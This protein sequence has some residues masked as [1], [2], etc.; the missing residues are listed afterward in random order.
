V[1]A[2]Q[3]AF[4]A[5][6][7]AMRIEGLGEKIARRL[8]HENLLKDIADIYTLREHDQ[9]L[10]A[11]EG[12][13]EISVQ[14]LFAEIEGSKRRPFARV[15]F[16]LGIP[17]V[18]AQTARLLTQHFK[19]IDEMIAAAPEQFTEIYGIGNVV[20]R[21]IHN[22][23]HDERNLSRI[24]RLRKAGLYFAAGAEAQTGG[25]LSGK[26]VCVTGRVE[27]FTR[28]EWKEIIEA[29]GGFFVSSVSKST[30]LLLAGD[31]A[32]S[33]LA[34][35]QKLGVETMTAEELRG[36]LCDELPALSGELAQKWQAFSSET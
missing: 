25:F 28:D 22:F 13:A 11:L 10:V 21:E 4:F 20:A 19:D 16:A 6:R 32:G 5:A 3:I 33:K 15:L 26:K 36:V 1:V 31:E 7:G 35:A 8:V 17:Q 12:F 34:K 14:N 2:Q 18:G 23:L 9:E 29:S 27:P 24:E 30:D